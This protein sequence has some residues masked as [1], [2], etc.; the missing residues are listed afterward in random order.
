MLLL[1]LQASLARKATAPTAI[2]NAYTPPAAATGSVAG[3]GGSGGAT[4]I[5][6]YDKLLQ[7][8]LQPFMELAA[9][10]GG[11]VRGLAGHSLCVSLWLNHEHRPRGGKL[12]WS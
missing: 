12:S 5:A 4:G 1:L 10:L 11:E 6:A 3:G 9:A 7:E 2:N 8:H